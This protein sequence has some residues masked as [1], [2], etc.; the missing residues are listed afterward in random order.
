MRNP[1][2][3][4]NAFGTLETV[5]ETRWRKANSEERKAS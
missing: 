4:L 1:E 3:P 2:D 5:R